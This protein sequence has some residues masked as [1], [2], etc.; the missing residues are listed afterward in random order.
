M[1]WARVDPEHIAGNPAGL[2]PVDLAENPFGIDDDPASEQAE[3]IGIEDARGDELELIDLT[4]AFNRVAGIVPT[5]RTHNHLGAGGKDINDLAFSL[6]APLNPDNY[7][8]RHVKNLL[9]ILVK[10]IQSVKNAGLDSGNRVP[11]HHQPVYQNFCPRAT[12]VYFLF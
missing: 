6:I 4:I 10:K 5:L 9:S 8:S 3:G 7:F 11:K 2:Q 12:V 1:T